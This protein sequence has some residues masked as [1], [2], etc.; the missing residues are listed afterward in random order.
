MELADI[1]ARVEE[2]TQ[3]KETRGKKEGTSKESSVSERTQGRRMPNRSHAAR[4]VVSLRG[5]GVHGGN[6]SGVSTHS[7]HLT[8]AHGKSAGEEVGAPFLI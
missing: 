1:R 6:A 3:V 7:Y 4:V 5:G 2:E 8:C